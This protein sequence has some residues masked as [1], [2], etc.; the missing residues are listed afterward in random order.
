MRKTKSKTSRGRPTIVVGD[1]VGRPT[2]DPLSEHLNITM[3]I[4]FVQRWLNDFGK[5][6]GDCIYNE[7]FTAPFV[8]PETILKTSVPLYGL[9]PAA[10]C[11]VQVKFMKP[12]SAYTLPLTL[13]NIQVPL[14]I[15]VLA[16]KQR[17]SVAMQL[18]VDAFRLLRKGKVLQD[19]ARTLE[20]YGFTA[21]SD[22][23]ALTLMLRPDFEYVPGQFVVAASTVDTE[24]NKENTKVPDEKKKPLKYATILQPKPGFF[25]NLQTFVASQFPVPEDARQ[26]YGAFK[27]AFG[28]LQADVRVTSTDMNAEALD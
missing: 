7:N 27:Q 18:P 10:T 24:A 28:Q 6:N 19:D 17:V 16:L 8:H 15:P 14:N 11:S 1:F 3:E 21:D 13:N 20:D 25:D 23:N 22:V 9:L 5:T 12:P 26:V 2:K 4:E